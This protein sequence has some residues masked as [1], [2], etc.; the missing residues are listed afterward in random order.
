[1]A[2]NGEFREKEKHGYGQSELEN[3]DVYEGEWHRGLMKE[4]L[5]TYRYN[6]YCKQGY[7]YSTCRVGYDPENDIKNGVNRWEQQVLLKQE[8]YE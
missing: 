5:K 7:I 1:M 6:K 3:G 4:G 2:Y 8:L